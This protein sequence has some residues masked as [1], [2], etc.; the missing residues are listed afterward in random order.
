MTSITPRLSVEGPDKDGDYTLVVKP[1]VWDKRSDVYETLLSPAEA[2]ALLQALQPAERPKCNCGATIAA[3]MGRGDGHAFDCTAAPPSGSAPERAD[4]LEDGSRLKVSVENAEN[5]KV[6]EPAPAPAGDGAPDDGDLAAWRAWQA[7]GKA[8]DGALRTAIWQS[9][10][11]LDIAKDF[12]H[13]SGA[14]P[15]AWIDTAT[16]RLREAVLDSFSAPAAPVPLVPPA[17]VE[18]MTDGDIVKP[19]DCTRHV[20]CPRCK[21][22]DGIYPIGDKRMNCLDCGHEWP[23]P[24]AGAR[25]PSEKSV[26][27]QD[28]GCKLT[29]FAAGGAAVKRCATHELRGQMADPASPKE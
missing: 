14:D 23:T 21:G 11:E 1:P 16:R 5:L 18:A 25:Q 29:V 15:E 12:L 7:Q 10:A 8:G 6:S 13:Q 22:A 26:V 28:C 2:S 3:E 19:C 9:I 27:V 17:G 24:E 4:K 20:H